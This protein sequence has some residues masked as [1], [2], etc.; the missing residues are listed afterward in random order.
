MS[1]L[2]NNTY[3]YEPVTSQTRNTYPP[4]H[5]TNAFSVAINRISRKPSHP[6]LS[7]VPFLGAPQISNGDAQPAK[8]AATS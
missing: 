6:G 8:L 5:S 7:Q 4:A 2:W 1:N 3:P